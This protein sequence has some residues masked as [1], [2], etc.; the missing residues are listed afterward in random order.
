MI[1]ANA[2]NSK[3]RRGCAA[4]DRGHAAAPFFYKKIMVP[5]T[6]IISILDIISCI[7]TIITRVIIIITVNENNPAPPLKHN[8]LV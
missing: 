5:H 8:I 2:L 3:R 7:N 4:P 6:L 1:A